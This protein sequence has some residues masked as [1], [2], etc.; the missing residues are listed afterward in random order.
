MN[1]YIYICIYNI[2]HG[3]NIVLCTNQR[4]AIAHD[5]RRS[6]IH[7]YRK[8]VIIHLKVIFFIKI[9]S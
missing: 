5:L 7:D 6:A 3:C 2:I 9:L 8:G 4:G 1:E